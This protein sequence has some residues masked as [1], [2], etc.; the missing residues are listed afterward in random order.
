MIGGRNALVVLSGSMFSLWSASASAAVPNQPAKPCAS[1]D[2][3]VEVYATGGVIRPSLADSMFESPA[4]T[5]TTGA[6]GAPG[7]RGAGTPGGGTGGAMVGMTGGV[8]VGVA[9]SS[10]PQPNIC[11]PISSARKELVEVRNM[12]ASFSRPTAATP[13]HGPTP[14][15]AAGVQHTPL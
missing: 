2:L 1:S 9:G 4:R 11:A 14:R 13:C 15:D 12:L 6:G 7:G 8:G 10:P 5:T 3:T